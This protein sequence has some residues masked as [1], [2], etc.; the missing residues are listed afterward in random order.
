MT[1]RGKTLPHQESLDIELAEEKPAKRSIITAEE[2]TEI[3]RLE[4]LDTCMVK[5]LKHLVYNSVFKKIFNIIYVS[6][7]A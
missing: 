2:L 4:D 6:G 1:K 3:E 5:Q 7:V